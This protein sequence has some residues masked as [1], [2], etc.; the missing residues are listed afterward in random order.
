MRINFIKIS[1]ILFTIPI[2]TKNSTS[3]FSS[4]FKKHKEEVVHQEFNDL[5]KLEI[6]NLYGDISVETW[7]QQCVMIELHKKGSADFFKNSKLKHIL[8]NHT[9]IAHTEI[10]EKQ[11]GRI[12]IRIQD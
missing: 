9:L 8:K 4:F 7:K 3:S 10:Q 1:L 2:V 6:T 12:H 5:K 11:S